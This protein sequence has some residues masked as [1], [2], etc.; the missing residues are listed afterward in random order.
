MAK[1]QNISQDLYDLLVSRG[2][3]VESTNQMGQESQPQDARTFTFDWVSSGGENYGTAVAVITDEQ[4][5]L[6]FYGDNLGRGMEQQDKDEWFEFLQ[7]LRDFATRHDFHTFSPRNLNRLNDTLRSMANIKEGLFESYY[8]NRQVSYMGKPTE[9]RLRIQHSRPLGEGDARYRNIQALFIETADSE[10][11]RLPFTNLVGGRAMLEHV[12]QGGRP[13]DVRG[14][15]IGNMVHEAKL[16]TRFRRAQQGR[17]LEGNTQE[18]S[19]KV[20]TY[21]QNLRENLRTLSTPRGYRAY[22]ETWEFGEPAQTDALVEDL[23]TMF[24]EQ[25]LDQRIEDALPLLARIQ[26]TAMQEAEIF[27]NWADRIVEGTW[28]LPDTPEAEKK[29]NDL[30]KQELPV[31]P[32]ATNATEQLYDIFGDDE[33]FDRLSE[34]A[35][36]DPDA[37][38]RDII[39]GRASEVGIEIEEPTDIVEPKNEPEPDSTEPAAADDQETVPPATV[40]QPNATPDQANPVREAAGQKKRSQLVRTDSGTAAIGSKGVQFD[41]SGYQQVFFWPE[42]KKMNLGGRVRGFRLLKDHPYYRPGVVN[43][44]GTPDEEHHLPVKYIPKDIDE[45]DNLATFV[46]PNESQ[47]SELMWSDLGENLSVDEKIEILEEYYVNGSLLESNDSNMKDYFLSLDKMSTP[48]I[49][50]QQYVVVPLLLTGNRVRLLDRV[51]HRTYLGRSSDGLVFGDRYSRHTYPSKKI[52][53][54]SVWN[55]FTFA[56]PESYDRFRTIIKLK[57]GYELLPYNQITRNT[58][59]TDEVFSDQQPVPTSGTTDDEQLIAREDSTDP[60]DHRG[61]ATDSFYE[62]LARIKSLALSK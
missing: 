35:Q 40:A 54:I 34:L 57:F 33:L 26:G 23:K 29:L 43:V 20:D 19:S 13:Y 2:F 46:G 17:V 61:A 6:L 16:L 50:K 31:G 24:I 1:E 44:Y 48:P 51:S 49:K 36:R 58:E 9:A 28:S 21:Y 47:H 14:V 10:R 59:R 60:M 55:T 18:L 7:Q 4:E 27:E 53:D 11:F 37:D 15:H 32:D 62:D 12:R 5:L 8:G 45:G 42:I 38:A 22:F 41:N 25:T 39:R 3:K 30:M 52:R 56:D